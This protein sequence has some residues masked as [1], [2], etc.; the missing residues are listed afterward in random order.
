M[1]KENVYTWLFLI[2]LTLSS[3]LFSTHNGHS[4][5]YILLGLAVVKF[6]SV[7]FQFMEL[8]KAHVFWKTSVYVFLFLFVSVL[9]I[10]MK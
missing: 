5:V 9:F 10:I 4:A 1:K 6:I 2:V 8:K 7:A 3:V